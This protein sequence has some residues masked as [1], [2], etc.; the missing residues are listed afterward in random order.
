V[1]GSSYAAV[2]TDVPFGVVAIVM[3]P[4]ISVIVLIDVPLLVYCIVLLLIL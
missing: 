1:L 3:L 2:Y 4:L